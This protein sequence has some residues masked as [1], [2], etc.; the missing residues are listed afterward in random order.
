MASIFKRA[1]GE[2]SDVS[3]NMTPM[4]DCTFQLIIFFILASQVASM[5]LAKL[6]LP[7][8]HES[9][10][11]DD[12]KLKIVSKV[13]VNVVSA[14]GDRKDAAPDLQA[15]AGKYQIE[16]KD[17]PVGD[18]ERLERELKRRLG[19]STDAGVK[20][21]D[22]YVMIR[23]DKRV[24]YSGVVPVMKAAANVG[25]EKMTLTALQ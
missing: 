8:P 25:I 3:F 5:A 13:I 2:D 4:I 7:E 19:L 6:E 24:H 20:P 23:A 11:W 10:A 9:M 16:G 22:F 12:E 21:A 1:P 18:M 17:Y 14:A 15:R